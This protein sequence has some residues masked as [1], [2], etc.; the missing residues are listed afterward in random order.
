M[1]RRF[2][3]RFAKFLRTSTILSLVTYKITMSVKCEMQNS[4]IW[5]G[6]KICS[7]FG[8]WR[9]VL[10]VAL[11]KYICKSFNIVDHYLHNFM[12]HI[13]HA[14]CHLIWCRMTYELDHHLS[15]S[16]RQHC[17]LKVIPVE[18]LNFVLDYKAVI[19]SKISQENNISSSMS[20]LRCCK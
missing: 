16:T 12:N 2:S 9:L 10:A 20:S 15:C 18:T 3:Y 19:F 4:Y 5:T 7:S 14:S 13:S 11:F 17:A 6:S 1:V 8:H